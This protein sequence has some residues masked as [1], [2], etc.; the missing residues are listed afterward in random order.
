MGVRDEKKEERMN[1]E[2]WIEYVPRDLESMEVYLERV[3]ASEEME[4]VMMRLTEE[5][6]EVVGKSYEITAI[7]HAYIKGLYAVM[8][9]R[10]LIFLTYT[11]RW[12]NGSN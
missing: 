10:D 12:S 2:W 1:H 7:R 3:T 9:I 4:F 5:D 8:V 6:L 11:D